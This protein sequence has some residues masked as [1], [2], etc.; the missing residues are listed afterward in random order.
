MKKIK[1]VK[2][3]VISLFSMYM[4]VKFSMYMCAKHSD[5][6]NIKGVKYNSGATIK[7]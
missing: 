4:H 6:Y 5:L 3:G 1:G 7:Q 2:N